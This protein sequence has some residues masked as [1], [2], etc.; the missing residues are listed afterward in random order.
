MKIR[1]RLVG[2]TMQTLQYRI[3]IKFFGGSFFL[4]VKSQRKRGCIIR[5]AILREGAIPITLA[6]HLLVSYNPVYSTGKVIMEFLFCN[7]RF[8]FSTSKTT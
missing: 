5:T 8:V 6:L 3:C 2:V 4:L 7:K 1:P